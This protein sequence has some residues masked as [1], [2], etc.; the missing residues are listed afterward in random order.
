MVTSEPRPIRYDVTPDW[1]RSAMTVQAMVWR[2]PCLPTQVRSSLTGSAAAASRGMPSRISARSSSSTNGTSQN[3][4]PATSDIDTPD[5]SSQAR[6]K[7][8]IWPCES[9]TMIRLGAVSRIADTKSRSARSS[10][11]A[12]T[13][14]VMSRAMPW[15]PSMPPAGDDRPDVLADPDLDAVLLADRELEVG[16]LA[17]LR[18]LLVEAHRARHPVGPHQLEVLHRQQLALVEAEDARR[19]RVDEREPAERVGPVNHVA[20]VVD[21]VAVAALGAF[22]RLGA[23]LHLPVQRAVPHRAA[24]EQ[25]QHERAAEGE[26]RR[27]AI[28]PGAAHRT[29]Q[30]LLDEAVELA[31]VL[32][33]V[34]RD[35]QRRDD[36]LA[37]GQHREV[38]RP[39]DQ[40]HFD[41]VLRQRPHQETH[42]QVIARGAV[43]LAALERADLV[44]ASRDDG[45]GRPA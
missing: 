15:K 8:T 39:R 20:G 32:Q 9:S 41:G 42:R 10:D 11:C 7:R 4:W 17:R 5:S 12:L 24:G 34:E 31:V 19:D 29:A 6:L 21:Q 35:A 26:D 45:Q 44:F 16:G 30:V 38:I 23:R 37:A 25:Q 43:D 28:Q 18:G 2:A 27:V 14:S 36:V 22:H 3:G 40:R 13:R 1:P 33:P